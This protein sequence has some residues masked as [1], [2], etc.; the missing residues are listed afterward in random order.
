MSNIYST[1]DSAHPEEKSYPAGVWFME[2]LVAHSYALRKATEKV[3]N[4][5]LMD[6]IVEC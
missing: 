6:F 5:P 2:I 1:H 4:S 3:K